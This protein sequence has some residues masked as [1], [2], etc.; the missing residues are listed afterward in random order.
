MPVSL[1]YILNMGDMYLI[2]VSLLIK[3]LKW[4]FISSSS[5]SISNSFVI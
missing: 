5:V 1:V 3:P 4:D 2:A